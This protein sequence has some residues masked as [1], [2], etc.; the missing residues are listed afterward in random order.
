MEVAAATGRLELLKL[1]L[2][3][4]A[5][6][7]PD[8]PLAERTSV[9]V[10]NPLSLAAYYNQTNAM[11]ILV[12]AGAEVNRTDGRG[13]TA[14]HWAVLSGTT[15]AAA[16]LLKHKAD[17]DQATA[18][19]DLR[20]LDLRQLGMG[21]PEQ[22]KPGESPLHVAVLCGQ[23]NLVRLLLQ[24]GAAVNAVDGR[25]LTPLD[26]ADR[27]R[28]MVG[29]FGADPMIQ[30]GMRLFL[31]PLGVSQRPVARPGLSEEQRALITQLIQA[32]GG[33][34]T[35]KIPGPGGRHERP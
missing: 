23:T 19:F 13:F 35:D 3:Y 14:L 10:P 28:S 4:H 16:W 17:A 31:Q 11:Q 22:A 2:K 6:V 34:H 24:S 9:G 12:Q 32:A 33:K 30:R 27:Q 26:L 8:S 18:R 15:E 25:G 20:R 7:D 21:P 5:P 29:T 1:L